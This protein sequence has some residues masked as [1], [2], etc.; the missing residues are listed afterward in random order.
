M[1]K[2]RIIVQTVIFCPLKGGL[3]TEVFAHRCLDN[4]TALLVSQRKEKMEQNNKTRF[5]RRLQ[6]QGGM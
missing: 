3:V 6:Q 5:Y 1:S 2:Y 4:Q